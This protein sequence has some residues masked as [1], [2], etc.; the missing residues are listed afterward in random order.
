MSR[1]QSRV[2]L[3][4]PLNASTASADSALTRVWSRSSVLP[5]SWTSIREERVSSAF[6][7]AASDGSLK[8]FLELIRSH[9]RIFT[10]CPLFDAYRRVLSIANPANFWNFCAASSEISFLDFSLVR[11]SYDVLL[12]FSTRFKSAHDWYR[13]VSFCRACYDGRTYADLDS[14][15]YKSRL[16]FGQ[17]LERS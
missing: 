5:L 12:T 6:C 11:K 7:V 16:L 3:T 1:S 4:K 15:P 9:T 2:L 17:S 13:L 14:L 10:H 8:L